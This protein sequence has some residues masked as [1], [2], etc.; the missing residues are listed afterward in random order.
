M[1]EKKIHRWGEFADPTEGPMPG[2]KISQGEYLNKELI[3]LQ[4]KVIPSKKREESECLCLQVKMN[5]ELRV[6]FTGSGVLLKQCRQ[7]AE[8]MPFVGKI[9]KVDKYLTFAD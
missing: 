3:A 1:E 7:Y 4:F 5:D 2:K 9:I 6:I 8:Q